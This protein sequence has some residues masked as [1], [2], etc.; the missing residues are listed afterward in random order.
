VQSCCF[1]FITSVGGCINSFDSFS[2][3]I[4]SSL[5]IG[6]MNRAVKRF[7]DMAEMVKMLQSSK[8]QHL[9]KFGNNTIIFWYKILKDKFAGY[10]YYIAIFL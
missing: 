6:S 4:Q 1:S 2:S 5:I 9:I 8:C 7:S 10:V 3:D